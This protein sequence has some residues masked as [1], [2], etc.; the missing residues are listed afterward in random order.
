MAWE[1]QSPLISAC[2]ETVSRDRRHGDPF[3]LPLQAMNSVDPEPGIQLRLQLMNEAVKSVNGLAGSMMNSRKYP[4]RSHGSWSP[5][6]VQQVVL[7]D[8][9]ERVSKF[10]CCPLE[11]R[12][13]DAL[14]ELTKSANLYSQE[15]SHLASFDVGRIK[16][17]KRRLRPMDA[18]ALCPPNVREMLKH[19]AQFIEKTDEEIQLGE[20]TG[21][22]EPYWDPV[23]KKDREKRKELYIALWNS[24]LLCFRRR[25]KSTIGF[26]TVHKKDGMQR[27]ILDCRIANTCHKRPPTTRLA[28]PASFRGIDMTE[29]TFSSRGFGGI[30]GD[31]AGNEGDVGDCFYNFAIPGLA[32]YVATRDAFTTWELERMG[33]AATNLL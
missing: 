17:F 11:M 27:L 5:T 21:P 2:A 4:K 23:L 3:P 1:G 9:E 8:M 33:N 30:M 25:R 31:A 32:S 12:E 15:A 6:F 10:A 29:D 13:E 7:K 19:Q 22:V 28:T 14:K 18:S 24:G 16:I 20:V 26:F